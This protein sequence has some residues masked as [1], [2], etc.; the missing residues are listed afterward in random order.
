MTAF[1]KKGVESSTMLLLGI[2]IVVI[3]IV[4]IAILAGGWGEKSSGL[5]N[6]V[7]PLVFFLPRK[8]LLDL[9]L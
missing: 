8:R 1:S 4:T 2:I 7:F 3:A 9:G 6:K 5:I